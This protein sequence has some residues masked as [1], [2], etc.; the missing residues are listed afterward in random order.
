MSM[1]VENG[2]LSAGK[3]ATPSP[4]L[5]IALEPS[6]LHALIERETT[7][8]ASVAAGDVR[9]VM[10]SETELG[11]AHRDV[12]AAGRRRVCRPRRLASSDSAS[13]TPPG[14]PSRTSAARRRPACSSSTRSPRGRNPS[15]RSRRSSRRATCRRRWPTSSSTRPSGSGTSTT[16][17][18][19]G[20]WPAVTGREGT[21]VDAPRRRSGV[22]GS[23]R[24]TPNTRWRRRTRATRRSWQPPH[25]ARVRSPTSAS[26]SAPSRSSCGAGSRARSR[27]RSCAPAAAGR[28]TRGADGRCDTRRVA[29]RILGDGRLFARHRGRRPPA[30]PRPRA[31]NPL[32]PDA[33][34]CAGHGADVVLRRVRPTRRTLTR[35][36]QPLAAPRPA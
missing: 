21:A 19:Q 4:T 15:P 20:S 1:T 24:R 23:V 22:A 17:S 18:S 31:A 8:A 16:R 6:A 28:L 10:G 14:L 29:G 7:V 33:G 3:Y 27:G 5:A 9:I 30:R 36:V 2:E 26:G 34:P 13:W 11:T 35:P 12:R 32:R 25:S